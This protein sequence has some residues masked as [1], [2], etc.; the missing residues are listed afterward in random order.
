MNTHQ[1]DDRGAV[2]SLRHVRTEQEM[3]FA[4]SR[5]VRTRSRI[6]TAGSAVPSAGPVGATCRLAGAQLRLLCG[7][8]DARLM[9]RVCALFVTPIWLCS[10]RSDS[11]AI[12][13]LRTAPTNEV[14]AAVAR[15]G[16]V[17][18]RAS[19]SLVQHHCRRCPG[20]VRVPGAAYAR[21]PRGVELGAPAS[22]GNLVGEV[23][24]SA[25]RK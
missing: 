17:G 1:C 12:R 25:P 22:L 13:S 7:E 23:H 8:S 4:I 20:I 16:G 24:G 10:A 3:V 2:A 5:G 9:V 18:T 14:T 11:E 21:A 15:F 6:H 19:D